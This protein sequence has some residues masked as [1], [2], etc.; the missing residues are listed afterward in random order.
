[1]K[2]ILTHYLFATDMLSNRIVATAHPYHRLVIS[3]DGKF[4]DEDM[5]IMAATQLCNKLGWHNDLVSGQLPNG[6]WAHC[7]TPQRKRKII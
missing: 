2:A 7:F 1:M 6:D 5:N 3:V 4:C